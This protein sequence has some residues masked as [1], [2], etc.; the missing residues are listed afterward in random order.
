MR[1][2][3]AFF[4]N[5][6]HC[7]AVRFDGQACVQLLTDQDMIVSQT[8]LSHTA[9]GHILAAPGGCHAVETIE[10]GLLDLSDIAGTLLEI[11]GFSRTELHSVEI[12]L[13]RY[14]L[15]SGITLFFDSMEKIVL[16]GFIRKHQP[17]GM[18]DLRVF[19]PSF[20]AASRASVSS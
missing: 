9:A 3:A 4:D 10:E 14:R 11:P 16:E 6:A 1:V 15:R 2:R 7:V 19:F 18:E 8:A 13:S 20:S 5:E 17:M 12:Q